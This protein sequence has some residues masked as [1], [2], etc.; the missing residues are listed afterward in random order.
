[1]SKF[2]KSKKY[3]GVYYRL[4]KDGDRTYYF[5]YRDENK[6]SIFHKVGL[7]SEGYNELKTYQMRIDTIDKKQDGINVD[8]PNEKKKKYNT[9][10]DDM[11]DFYFTNHQ[12]K[13]S[14]R[15]Q[16]SYNNRIKPIL[17][18]KS[19]YNITPKDIMYF[20]DHLSQEVSPQTVIVYLDL[21]STI[22]NFY[23]RHH[24]ITL[25][26]PT[27]NIKKP[28]VDNKRERVLSKDE[29][30]LIFSN[31]GTDLT[32]TLFLSLSLCTGARKSTVMN[33]S[34]KD[35]DF[36]HKTINS[37]DFKN[38]SS[39]KS[40][41]DSRTIELIKLRIQQNDDPNS[42]LIY[43][44][45]IHDLD[46]YISRQFKIVFDNLFNIGLDENDRKNRVVIHTLRHTVLSHLGMKG[47]NV[48][49]LKKISNHKSTQ[50]VE[51]YTKLSEDSG[52]KEIE[53]LWD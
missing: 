43:K 3:T 7:R 47:C 34:V 38:Q 30:D 9:T 10:L 53:N 25:A 8:T 4:K 2:I 6:K 35:V 21:I 24:Q 31:I 36:F 52:R 5:T 27:I 19:I 40:F 23:R 11:S 1:V 15:R 12:T 14:P 22:Y 17:G 45:D 48:F 13:T 16:R 32:L 44:P 46:R 28:T 33:Y 49:L 50:M 42:K 51:R 26:N 20:Q 29:I 39:Y 37:Y 18:H 41:L